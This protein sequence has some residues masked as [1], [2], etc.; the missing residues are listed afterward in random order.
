MKV[1]DYRSIVLLF[2]RK[3]CI[4]SSDDTLTGPGGSSNY[5]DSESLDSGDAGDE[6]DAAFLE[7][8]S[9]LA[10]QM[11]PLDTA[12][13]GGVSRRINRFS[14]TVRMLCMLA[15]WSLLVR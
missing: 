6:D 7:T 11:P 10:S 14:I 1:G 2:V 13:G 8:W 3:M 15:A 9:A 4:P 5:E 12:S